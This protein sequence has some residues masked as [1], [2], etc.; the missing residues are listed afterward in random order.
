MK[1]IIAWM[2]ALMLPLCTAAETAAQT[3]AAWFYPVLVRENSLMHLLTDEQL[4]QLAVMPSENVHAVVEAMFTA[5]AGVA[6]WDELQVWKRLTGQAARD[7]RSAENAVYRAKTAPWLVQ[8]FAPGLRPL[9]EETAM[10]TERPTVEAKAV[11][12]PDETEQAEE[13]AEPQWTL[14][15][16]LAALQSNEMGRMYLSLLESIGGRDAQSCMAITQAVIQRWLAEIDHEKLRGIN[17]HY[18]FWLYAAGTPIDYPVVQCGN[19]SYYMDR[20]FNRKTNKTGTLFADYRNLPGFRDPNT[21]VY[22]HHM[23]DGSMFHSLTDYESR[24][25]YDAHPWMVAVQE[26]EIWLIEVFAGYV[27]DGRDHCYDIAISD[28]ADMRAFVEA[29]QKKSNFD[30][31]VEIECR[32][33]HL[34]TLSTCAYNYDNARYIVIGRLVSVWEK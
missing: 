28:E 4:E 15:D 20:M 19:N 25:F 33:D 12:V 7:A 21:L 18:Q 16:G 23:R 6:E 31:H 26:D 32:K 14:E 29:A 9:Q 24:G 5:A 3:G 22:G 17:D 34:V 27:T 8:A 30:S 10:I 11:S 2:A 13:S 1:K